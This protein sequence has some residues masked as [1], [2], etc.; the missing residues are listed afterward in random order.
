MQ[1]TTICISTQTRDKL[2]SLLYKT[3]TYDSGIVRL[4]T[5]ASPLPLS[6]SPQ[7]SR[8]PGLIT[9]QQEGALPVK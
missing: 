8:E 3:E 4:I 5:T 6:R 7:K 1:K 2:K 9:I